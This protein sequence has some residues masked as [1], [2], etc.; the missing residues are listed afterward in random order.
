MEIWA[1]GYFNIDD[2]FVLGD[3]ALSEEDAAESVIE[4]EGLFDRPY[5]YDVWL[6]DPR[7]G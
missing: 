4:L 3:L 5:V 2:E 7:E 1:I 6:V